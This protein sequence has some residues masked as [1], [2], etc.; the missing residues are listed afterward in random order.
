MTKDCTREENSEIQ[1]TQ[2]IDRFSPL[3]ARKGGATRP[4]FAEP[5]PVLT[6][7]IPVS[8]P[9]AYLLY[10]TLID[11]EVVWTDS[12]LVGDLFETCRTS[13]R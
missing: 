4:I 10:E 3:L 12:V 5:I 2:C 1:L 13:R 9:W 6:I 11:Y 7:K 8:K